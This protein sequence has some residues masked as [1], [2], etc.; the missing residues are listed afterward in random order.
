MKTEAP[1]PQVPS[2]FSRS[3]AVFKRER[4]IEQQTKTFPLA[5]VVINKPRVNPFPS[6]VRFAEDV[7]EIQSLKVNT[8]W[9]RHKPRA[10]TI[11]RRVRCLHDLRPEAECFNGPFATRQLVEFELD[12]KILRVEAESAWLGRFLAS[13]GEAKRV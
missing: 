7:F 6:L 5:L 13:L 1:R 11:S 3:L 8:R 9:L 10:Q 2:F 12:D 4:G